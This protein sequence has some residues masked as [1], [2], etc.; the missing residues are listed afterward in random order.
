YHSNQKLVDLKELGI[1]TYI[2]EPKRGRRNWTGKAAE[3]DAVYANRRRIRG[4][5]GKKLLRQRGLILERPFAHCYETGGM[6]RLHLRGRENAAKRLL[7]HAAAFNLGL[8]MRLK[9][10]LAKP[11]SLSNKAA[12]AAAAVCALVFA[13]VRRLQAL[14]T[15]II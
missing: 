1:R 11:R 3:R 2:S 6:R 10:G 15:G 4:E 12:A 14:G 8:V 5:R 9:Y 13:L 7:V